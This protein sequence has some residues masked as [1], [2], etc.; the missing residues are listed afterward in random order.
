[1]TMPRPTEG[2]WGI[3][4]SLLLVDRGVADLLGSFNGGILLVSRDT[5]GSYQFTKP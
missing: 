5:H 4:G 1:M 3:F 2:L